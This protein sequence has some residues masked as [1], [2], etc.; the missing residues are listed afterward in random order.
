MM[1][2]ISRMWENT[3]FWQRERERGKRLEPQDPIFDA[4]PDPPEELR[5]P[6]TRGEWNRFQLSLKKSMVDAQRNP[7]R[8]KYVTA[9]LRRRL[10]LDKSCELG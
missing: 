1:R 6:V 9:R 4:L 7:I 2:F 8:G 5:M 3:H 10:R